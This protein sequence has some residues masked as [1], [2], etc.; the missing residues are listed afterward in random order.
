[1]EGI[2]RI[3]NIPQVYQSLMFVGLCIVIRYVSLRWLERSAIKSADLKQR[4][5]IQ[6]RNFLYLFF[7][8]GVMFI[9]GAHLKNLVLSMLAVMA[10]IVIATKELILC[11]SGSFLKAASGSFSIGD[12]VVVGSFR[13]LVENQTLLST[14]LIEMSDDSK[15]HAQ[16]G[17]K[18][19]LPNSVF[20]TQAVLNENFSA[21]YQVSS[22]TII[23]D[24][25][26]KTEAFVKSSLTEL[27]EKYSYPT[28]ELIRSLKKNYSVKDYTAKFC[29]PM[30]YWSQD[31]AD[32]W[33]LMYR[34]V[35]PPKEI[36]A[37]EQFLLKSYYA[38]RA[39]LKAVEKAEKN[40]EG[41]K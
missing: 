16:T 4:W 10:A 39:E 24:L 30:V 36:S 17:R 34:I 9:W 13:G 28:D 31:G 11:L 23:T 40:K 6:A 18:V 2:Q 12:R 15:G 5:R 21:Q 26:D 38:Y 1:M 7:L 41:S 37:F 3:V 25:G 35:L 27:K 29:E 14:T 33:K 32:K 8:I 20:L 19:S 22:F